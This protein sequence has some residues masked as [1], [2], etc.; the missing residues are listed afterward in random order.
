MFI[1]IKCG[2]IPLRAI[3]INLE[4]AVVLAHS[5]FTSLL[6]ELEF[7]CVSISC[8]APCFCHATTSAHQFQFLYMCVH[9][10]SQY[11]AAANG[12]AVL[13]GFVAPHCC[14]VRLLKRLPNCN[15]VKMKTFNFFH[16]SINI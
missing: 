6:V 10:C 13:P 8:I 4:L 12:C 11:Y 15:I 9:C 14:S 5:C 16:Y 3:L 1:N 7:S 2:L